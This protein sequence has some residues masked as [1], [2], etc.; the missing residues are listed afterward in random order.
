MISQ[1]VKV[2]QQPLDH[3]H[4][5]QQLPAGRPNRTTTAQQEAKRV[6]PPGPTGEKV[7]EQVSLSIL[8]LLYFRLNNSADQ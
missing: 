5:P 7:Y 1:R 4:L 6:R 2:P 3:Y 8:S